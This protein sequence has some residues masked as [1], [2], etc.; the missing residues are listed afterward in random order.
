[1]QRHAQI[2]YQV[3]GR[4]NKDTRKVWLADEGN[5][6]T[7]FTKIK[8]LLKSKFIYLN[9]PEFIKLILLDN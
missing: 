2:Q 8:Y 6:F 9:L 3:G 4:I 7:K 1:M 5:L